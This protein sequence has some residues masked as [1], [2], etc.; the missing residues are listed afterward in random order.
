[1]KNR[2]NVRQFQVVL[3]FEYAS[4]LRNKVYV[5]ITVAFMLLIGIGLSLPSIIG[6]VRQLGIGDPREPTDPGPEQTIHVIDEAGLL[7]DLSLLKEAMP[8]ERFASASAA[9]LP[10]LKRTVN[11]GGARAV[12]H[13][14]S[15]ITFTLIERRAGSDLPG[16]LLQYLTVRYREQLLASYGLA[17]GQIEAAMIQPVI[18][19]VETVAETGK[20]MEQAFPYTY[21]LL[22]LLYMTVMMYG[23]LVASSVAS[24]KSNRAME[25]LITSTR[26]MNLMF[27]KVIGSGLAGLT[28]IGLFFLTAA[29][30]YGINRGAWSD[31]PII[32]S[33]FQMPAGI[34]AFTILFYLLGYFMYAFLYGALGSL[35]SR[36]EDINTSIMPVILVIMVAMFISMFGMM[37]PESG[38]LKASSFVPFIAP[39]AM[40]VRIS[41]TEVPAWQIALSVAGMFLTIYGT[42]W[43]SSRIYRLGV[44]MYGK[45][46]HAG[47]LLRLLRKAGK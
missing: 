10:E 5:G 44:L 42:G 30:F 1:M 46:P 33:I 35:A 38:I 29:V 41:M 21:L 2:F 7:G 40:F 34:L 9:D 14:E 12:L 47:E 19:H 45:P 28:Q 4:Y 15:E 24:E 39:M 43:L 17:S 16:R 3:S 27:G 25:M 36:T 18:T 31:I 20:T 23:Q 26:P 11:D 37:A 6:F 32:R 8:Q 13:L 22:F